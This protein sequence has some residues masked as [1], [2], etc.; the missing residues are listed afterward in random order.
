M[1]TVLVTIFSLAYLLCLT[2]CRTPDSDRIKYLPTIYPW[3]SIF[4]FK[5]KA[6]AN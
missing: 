3:D 1:L 4:T 2:A 5:W 6:A